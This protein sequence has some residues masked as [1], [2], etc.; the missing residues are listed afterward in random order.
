[1]AK[2]IKIE[3]IFSDEKL[4]GDGKDDPFR[5]AEQYF[6]PDGVLVFEYDPHKDEISMTANMLDYLREKVK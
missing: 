5:R 3:L 1:M 4:L 2:L 6:S